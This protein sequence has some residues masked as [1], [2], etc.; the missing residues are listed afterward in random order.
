[1]DL[2]VASI[3][4]F[5]DGHLSSLGQEEISVEKKNLLNKIVAEAVGDGNQQPLGCT[6]WTKHCIEVGNA[7]SVTESIIPFRANSRKKC[8]RRCV[9]YWRTG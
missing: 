4:E 7:R 1:M 3:F 6:T 9:T 8:L 2:E 5:E